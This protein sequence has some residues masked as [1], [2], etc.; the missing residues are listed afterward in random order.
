[1]NSQFLLDTPLGNVVKG[2]TLPTKAAKL[3]SII[4]DFGI[5]DRKLTAL[6]NLNVMN[7]LLIV[8]S[9]VEEKIEEFKKSGTVQV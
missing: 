4:K 9:L 7:L 5:K 6:S 3:I 1:M 2:S 8:S